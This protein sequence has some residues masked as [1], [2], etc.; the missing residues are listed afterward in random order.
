MAT[1]SL[2]IQAHPTEVLSLDWN[3]Y[4]P[5]LIATGSVDKTLK[6]HDLRMASSSGIKSP[7]IVTVMAHDYAVR[8]VAW[9]PHNASSIATA[10]YDMTAKIWSI[11]APGLELGQSL[12]NQL[13]D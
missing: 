13:A 7:T 9:S 8:R 12:M 5:H 4:A 2:A 1:P 10:S 3:K 6:I 11:N